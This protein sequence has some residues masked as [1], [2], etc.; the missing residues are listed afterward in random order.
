[1]CVCVLVWIWSDVQMEPVSLYTQMN[2]IYSRFPAPDYPLLVPLPFLFSV[3]LHGMTFPFLFDKNPL[4]TH[5]N[6]NI[7]LSQNCRPPMFSVP[8]W[9]LHPFQ[10]FWAF[11]ARFWAVL[12][13]LSFVW[14]ECLCVRVPPCVC[15]GVY[16]L[17]IISRDKILHFK[18][19]LIIMNY[20]Y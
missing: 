3:H 1:M 11:A 16:V 10:V 19:T 15:G 5:S 14:S 20:Y 13:F 17:R 18:N 7:V 2:Y 6:L 4:W 8:F 9:C 12:I